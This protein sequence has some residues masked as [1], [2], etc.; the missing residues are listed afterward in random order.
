MRPRRMATRHPPPPPPTTPV[1]PPTPSPPREPPPRPA[2]CESGGAHGTERLLV[3]HL[4]E[5]SFAVDAYTSRPQ[6]KKKTN[7]HCQQ[8]EAKSS[9]FAYQHDSGS[10]KRHAITTSK[11]ATERA[12]RTTGRQH[13]H[14]R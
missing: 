7:A 2:G 6:K 11:S 10:K 12:A 4:P 1:P 3:A 8:Y 9:S 14:E 5:F 13:R